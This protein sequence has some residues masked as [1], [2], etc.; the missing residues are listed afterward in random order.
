MGT[1]ATILISFWFTRPTHI[2]SLT[3]HKQLKLP[4]T[5]SCL[6]T[7]N[8]WSYSFLLFILV[9]QHSWCTTSVPDV[10]RFTDFIYNDTCY[11]STMIKNFIKEAKLVPSNIAVD[12]ILQAM[13]RSGKKK[14][15][16]DG[17]PRNEE[18]RVA[19]LIDGFPRS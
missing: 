3:F 19:F 10:V 11:Y 12:L 2:T 14:F 7:E 6:L 16:I 5:R 4:Q 13:S 8:K 17:F 9:K 18:N 15:L 1:Y